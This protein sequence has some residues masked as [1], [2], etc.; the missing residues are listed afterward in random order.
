MVALV[1]LH[2]FQAHFRPDEV[3]ELVGRNLSQ[4]FEPGDFR[5]RTE[6]VDGRKAL[7]LAVAVNGLKLRAVGALRLSEDG[8]AGAL[9]VDADRFGRRTDFLFLIPDA[10]QGRL[11]DIDVA[12]L[13]EVG[14]KL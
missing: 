10:E 7:F 2:L 9:L 5:V 8:G 12:F 1:Q 14:E 3:L 4:S 13:D 11:K 6:T